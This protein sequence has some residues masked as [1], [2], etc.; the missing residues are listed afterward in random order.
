MNIKIELGNKNS[1]QKAIKEIE[2]YKKTL[3]SKVE[4]FL[5]R[6]GEL[7]VNIANTYISAYSIPSEVIGQIKIQKGD[8]VVSGGTIQIIITNDEALFWEYGT[9][10]VGKDNP[11]I[12]TNGWTYN[13]NDYKKGWVYKGLGTAYSWELQD[14]NG[15]Y[16]TKGMPSQPF[17][18]QTYNDL[19]KNNWSQIISIAKEV[20]S[21]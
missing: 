16:F 8:I 17:M 13:V 14:K 11:H 6:V 21:K 19:L 12:D 2:R 20:F 1:I 5:L 4:T 7:G 9:G 18:Y 10:L 15:V 3:K